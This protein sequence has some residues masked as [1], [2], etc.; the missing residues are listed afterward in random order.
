LIG[1][2]A[3]LTG[4]SAIVRPTASSVPEPGTSVLMAAGLV[5]LLSSIRSKHASSLARNP[6]RMDNAQ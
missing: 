2:P 5:V 6:S 3:Q 4:G 1:D